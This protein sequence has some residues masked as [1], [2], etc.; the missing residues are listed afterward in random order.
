LQAGGHSSRSLLIGRGS[1]VVVDL[2]DRVDPVVRAG[3]RERAA[4]RV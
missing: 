3:S 2:A 1:V 4:C